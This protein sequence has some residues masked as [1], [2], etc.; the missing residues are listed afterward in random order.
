MN[1][2]T[3]QTRISKLTTCAVPIL[4]SVGTTQVKTMRYTNLFNEYERPTLKSQR[5]ETVGSALLEIIGA[6][7]VVAGLYILANLFLGWN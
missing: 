2:L 5:Q 4:V 7:L 6:I 3:P 1:E